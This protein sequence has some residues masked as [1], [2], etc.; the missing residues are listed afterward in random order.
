MLLINNILIGSFISFRGL[1]G[2]LEEGFPC[3]FND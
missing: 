3:I 2:H 1:G